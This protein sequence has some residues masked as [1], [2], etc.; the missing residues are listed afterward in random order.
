VV[1]LNQPIVT[2]SSSFS[3]R[4][5]TSE[6]VTQITGCLVM[7]TKEQQLVCVCGRLETAHHSFSRWNIFFFDATQ[8]E[9]AK[10]AGE[11][12]YSNCV[13]FFFLFLFS[14]EWPTNKKNLFLELV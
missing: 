6:K 11:A 2:A 10:Y 3:S 1:F 5:T 14:P 13:T 4:E 7:H 8:K 9:Q 12:R